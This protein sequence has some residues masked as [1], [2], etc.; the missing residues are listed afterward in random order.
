MPD[1]AVI[2][3]EDNLNQVWNERD[4]NF[5]LKAAPGHRYVKLH[6]EW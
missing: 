3:M 5:R 1:E 6:P 4:P 2:I